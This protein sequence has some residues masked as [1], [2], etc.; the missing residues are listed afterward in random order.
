MG[1]ATLLKLYCQ[2]VRLSEMKFLT[3]SISLLKADSQ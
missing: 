2:I 3:A 1:I